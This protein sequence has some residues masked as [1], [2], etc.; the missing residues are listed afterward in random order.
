METLLD[1]DGHCVWHQRES[2]A[3]ERVLE[4]LQVESDSLRVG[5]SMGTSKRG[6]C[7]L[8]NSQA[9]LVFLLQNARLPDDGGAEE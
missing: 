9:G 5:E 3:V 7:A 1:S 6:R 4:S 2:R 8:Y